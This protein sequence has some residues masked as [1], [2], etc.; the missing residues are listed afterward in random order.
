MN[1]LEFLLVLK[2]IRDRGQNA[3][4]ASSRTCY[5]AI[6]S[7]TRR[8]VYG[9]NETRKPFRNQPIFLSLLSFLACAHH[10]LFEEGHLERSN[11]DGKKRGVAMG[12]ETR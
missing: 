9:G 4:N 3:E 1:E 10:L 7:D 5:Y 11:D 6:S 2:A 12:S 8:P